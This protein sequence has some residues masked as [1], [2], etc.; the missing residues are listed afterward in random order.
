MSVKTQQ[1]IEFCAAQ[2]VCSIVLTCNSQTRPDAQPKHSHPRFPI[3]FPLL[4]STTGCKI[5][6]QLRASCSTMRTA[7]AQS[8]PQP[9][10]TTCK[11]RRGR[12]TAACP[13]TADTFQDVTLHA[14]PRWA[15]S[16][17][18]KFSRPLPRHKHTAALATTLHLVSTVACEK[19]AILLHDDT[20]P[21]PP[22]PPHADCHLFRR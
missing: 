5:H 13:W 22:V 8:R 15:E 9:R 20:T 16:N 1:D 18:G 10:S 11:I 17:P 2:A 3:S 19:A 7:L 12:H 14:Q 21:T 4:A 6:R